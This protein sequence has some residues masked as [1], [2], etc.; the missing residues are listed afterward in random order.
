MIHLCQRLAKQSMLH[1]MSTNQ[2]PKTH[3]SSSSSL[4][5]SRLSYSLATPKFNSYTLMSKHFF[6]SG[7]NNRVNKDVKKAEKNKEN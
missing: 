7:R 4:F 6:A 2:N 1:I 5:H 3:L